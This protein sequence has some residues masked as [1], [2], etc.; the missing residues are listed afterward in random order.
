[1]PG[2][3]LLPQGKAVAVTPSA[4]A[5]LSTRANEAERQAA[6]KARP[7]PSARPLVTIGA[8]NRSESDTA[9]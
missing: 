2:I 8:F 3:S 7:K 9:R 4:G 6:L 1:M 5:R